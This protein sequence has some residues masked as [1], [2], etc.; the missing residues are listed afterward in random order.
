MINKDDIGAYICENKKDEI[1][2]EKYNING[3]KYI[4]QY[5]DET[6]AS[7]LF[8]CLNRMLVQ[9]DGYQ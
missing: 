5:T 6:K 8:N 3:I 7:D 4:I 1:I 2:I 9:K